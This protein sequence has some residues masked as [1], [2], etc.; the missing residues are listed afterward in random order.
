[1]TSFL[2]VGLLG[3]LQFYILPSSA[4]PFEGAGLSKLP[5]PEASRDPVMRRQA[6]RICR[7]R[8]SQ[9]HL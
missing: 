6:Q 2:R 3:I 4:V 9:L 1:M 7:R 8:A 5:D